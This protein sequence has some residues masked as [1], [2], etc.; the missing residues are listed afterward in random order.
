MTVIDKLE[1][2]FGWLAFPGFLRF[3]ALFHVLVFVIQ[4]IRPDVGQLF[5]F[6]RAKILSGEIWRVATFFF[7][8]SQFG[9][10]T[11]MSIVFLI[12]A[13]NFA[14]MIGD[15]LEGAWGAFKSTLFYYMGIVLTIVANFAYPF[16]IP[17]SGFVLYASAFLAFATLFPKTEILLMLFL[18]VQIRFLGILQGLVVLLMV[19][20]APILLPYVLLGFAN[21]IFLAG[22][23]A[24]RGT[25]R[26][27]EAGQRK[28]R[29]KAANA[30]TGEAFHT[31]VAC[32]R[33]DVSDPGME[34]RVGG[35]GREYCID[36]LRE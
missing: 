8:T 11:L 19:I 2:R 36:H 33:T 10:P 23:P 31:C 4:F 15:G 17:L 34:F 22:I 32:D 9:P 5:E 18:P 26:V 13:V 28:K 30:T 27:I 20:A 24:L 29:F 7:A 21:Y 6:D 35:D 1:R 25:A 14:F 12:F 3:Y 16:N